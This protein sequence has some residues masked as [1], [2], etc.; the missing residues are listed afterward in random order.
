MHSLGVGARDVVFHEPSEDADVWTLVDAY[1]AYD[2]RA[3]AAGA[4]SVMV[5][6]VLSAAHDLERLD[7][8][9]GGGT[10][11]NQRWPGRRNLKDRPAR[12]CF[13]YRPQWYLDDA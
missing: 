11:N 3:A 10:G 9:R 2:P 12:L 7:R 6:G 4:G 5:R 8:R 1:T 13:R